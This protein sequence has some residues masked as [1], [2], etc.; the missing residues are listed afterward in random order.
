MNPEELLLSELKSIMDEAGKSV[1]DDNRQ[2]AMKILG[3]LSDAFTADEPNNTGHHLY[4]LTEVP[5]DSMNEAAQ[6]P[7]TV[8]VERND[9]S[10]TDDR[11]SCGRVEH[12]AATDDPEV[13]IKGI[14]DAEAMTLIAYMRNP[15]ALMARLN[16]ED[17]SK[18]TIIALPDHVATECV[19]PSGSKVLRGYAVEEGKPDDYESYNE[20]EQV[21]IRDLYAALAMPAVF[22]NSY[23]E[24][25]EALAKEVEAKWREKHGD[26][27]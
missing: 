5:M 7:N 13:L 23:P 16:Y 26:T 19:S 22:R 2:E 11:V 3:L 4:S 21:L 15:H 27:D 17:G 20:H 18:F 9:I 12:L 10:R 1:K 25:F 6:E 24:S 8:M 14:Q